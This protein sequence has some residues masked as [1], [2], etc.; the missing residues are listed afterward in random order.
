MTHHQEFSGRLHALDNLRAVM[1]WLGIVLHVGIIYTFYPLP[2]PLPWHDQ[3]TSLWAD[4]LVALIHSFRMPVF[5][6]LAGFF[7]VLLVHARGVRGMLVNRL[8]RLG[9]PFVLLWPVIFVAMVWTVMLFA[10]RAAHGTWVLDP[11]QLDPSL[12]TPRANRH[13]LDDTMHL[14]F[15]WM[16]M[17]FS[18]LVAVLTPLARAVPQRLRGLLSRCFDQLAGSAWG[19]LP[20]T[21]PLALI[22]AMYKDGI[23]PASG[24][25]LAPVTEWL[26][27][28]IFFVFG[29]ALY[30]HRKRLFAIYQQRWKHNAVA[31][32]V[33]LTVMLTVTDLQR[34]HLLTVPNSAFWHAFLF[35]AS[36]W[37]LSFAWIGAFLRYVG[38]PHPVLDYLAQSSYWVYII[39][40][41]VTVGLGACLYSLDWPA[42]VKMPLNIAGTTVFSLL[43]YHLLVR[44]T[45]LGELLNGRR[46]PF[47]LLRLHAPVSRQT[48]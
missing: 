48:A 8:K 17:W 36:T 16:L 3:K 2:L 44:S 42:L 1:M 19:F 15:L 39:H 12:L 13:P 45:A 47:R 43:T 5:F 24:Y 10:Y 7:V 14:W 22:G 37:L 31:G 35:N 6:I 26:H 28:G 23:V 46:Y 18:V 11:S 21:I 20:L 27:N 38:R 40:M 25:F 32:L 33:V 9:L 30:A 29:L 4:W 34:Q 41:P